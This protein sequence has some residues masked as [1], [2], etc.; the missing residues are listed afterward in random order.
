MVRLASSLLAGV[1]GLAS[2]ASA[3]P[4]HNVKAEAAE[5]AAAL[6]NLHSRSL[7]GCA[8]NLRARGHEQGN[9]ARR[10]RAVQNLRRKR[11]LETRAPFLK[12][13]DDAPL[14]ITH[15]SSF[16]ATPSTDP[17]VLFA[18]N[19]SC[20]LAE[21]VTQG[22][23]YVS[24]ELI[25][26]NLVDG[27]EGV[28]LF[29]DIQLVDTNT[30][31]PVPEVYLDFWHC[32]ATGV[33]S[34]VTASGNGDSSD[35]SNLNAT[36][37]RGLQKTDKDGVAQ[38]ESIFPGHYTGRAT[39]IHVL[40]HPANETTVNKNDTISG[41]YTSSSS[42]VGQ[43]FFDQDLITEVEKNAPY[44][45]NTQELTE[46]SDD[47]ILLQELD[48]NIDPFMEYVYLGDSAADGIFAW[49]S[50]GI[51]PTVD[52]SVTPA[53]YYTHDGGVENE[54]SGMGMGGGGGAPPSAPGSA[55][56]SSASPSASA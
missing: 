46:N 20:I 12:A 36:F 21:D 35:E 30:C 45:T 54:N 15:H 29:L 8:T 14:N 26:S 53:A 48:S 16:D 40:S 4:G 38:F 25:R 28:P 55:S 18:S 49:I 6:N 47:D 11:G 43:I 50:V 42:H 9:V 23:Y 2:M 56:S 5:R 34:G 22:P 10:N 51:D 1:V 41:L 44:S 52:T 13:R 37:L 31:E 17:S 39:H 3:H 7:S 24:G 19:A 32:N 27:Q 33:Y